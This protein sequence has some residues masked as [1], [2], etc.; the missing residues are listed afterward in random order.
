MCAVGQGHA[1]IE[2]QNRYLY[3][4][5]Y[6]ETGMLRTDPTNFARER[7]VTYEKLG[8]PDACETLPF[9]EVVEIIM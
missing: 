8:I 2:T 3:K 5:S 1:H 7:I 9:H 6:N 4:L